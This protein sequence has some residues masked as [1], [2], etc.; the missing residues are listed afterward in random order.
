MRRAPSG[1]TLTAASEETGTA[2]PSDLVLR[3]D[4][5]VSSRSLGVG[6]RP[7]VIE[8]LSPARY[9]IQFTASTEL[10]EK[11]ER[12]R[13]LMRSSIPD[14]DLAAVI[15]AAV[16]EKLERLESR[17]FGRTKAHRKRTRDIDVSPASRHVP[18]GVRRDVHERDEGRCRYA[19]GQGRRCTEHVAVQL[20]HR[21]TFALGGDHSPGNVSLLCSAPQPLPGRDRLRP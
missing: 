4:E 1:P 6:A 15:D 14:G 19:D 2:A 11:L 18:A 16:T 17:R 5:V 8:P 7:A 9:K 20:H 21:H 12:L 13:I 3:L 10:R